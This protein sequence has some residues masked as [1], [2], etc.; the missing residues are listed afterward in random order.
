MARVYKNKRC[1]KTF[2]V[3]ILVVFSTSAMASNFN[4]ARIM[5]GKKVL[6]YRGDQQVG[7]LTAESPLPDGA[8]LG[9]HGDC[10][11]RMD[12]FML[13]GADQSLFSVTTQ[14]NSRELLVRDGT[15]FFAL[16]KLPHSLVFVT[17][18]G[19]VTVQQLILNAAADRSAIKGYVEVSGE[20]SEIGVIEG[21][22]M[23]VSTDDG[24]TTIQSGQKI[25]LA[26]N[27]AGGTTGYETDTSNEKRS[28]NWRT[29]AIVGGVLAAGAA[30]FAIASSSGGGGSGGDGNRS[31]SPSSP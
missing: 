23:R 16:S 8:L 22:S 2:I 1:L 29:A 7:E 19:A 5:P 12:D 13:I 4:S 24:E 30:A 25:I 18:E 3:I 15:V 17:P 31:S 26:Q 28:G 14:D 20:S 6:I 10:A 21:G 11:V 9:C 27:E